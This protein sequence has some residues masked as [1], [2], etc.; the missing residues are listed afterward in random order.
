MSNSEETTSEFV[1]TMY[2]LTFQRQV[3]KLLATN[4]KFAVNYG[5][6]IKGEYF[7]SVSLR[8]ISS[9]VKDFVNAYEK[10]V[11]LGTIVVKLDDYVSS[12]G[13]STDASKDILKEAKAIFN[14]NVNS[15]Q[16]I[17][18][19]LVSFARRQELKTA[20]YQSVEI[21]EKSEDYEKVLQLVDKAVG[22]GTGADEG[23]TFEDLYTLRENYA[24][25]YDT[26]KLIPTGFKKVDRCMEGGMAA[27]ELHVVQA[28]P[29]TGKSFFGVCV[30]AN[31]LRAGKSVFHVSFE[32]SKEEIAM[33]Y[34]QNL[35]KMEK[36]GVQS[37]DK[38]QYNHK[39]KLYEKYK[40]NLYMQYWTQKTAN[41]LDVRAWIS[42]IRAKKGVKPDLI[43]VDY[44]DLMLPTV[45]TKN[46]SMYEDAGQVYT[47]LITLGDYFQCPILTFAQPQREAWDLLSE[48]KVIESHHLAHSAMKA[49]KCHSIS[50]LNFSPKSDMGA[51]Y[52]DI[53]RRGTSG[54]NIKM[55][56]DLG[57][58][59]FHE[60][61]GVTT[62]ED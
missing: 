13:L 62:D 7:D 27:G 11:D 60:M 42:R 25:K 29:K 2:T 14:A 44:D 23:L 1:D 54:V 33:R 58:S 56:K 17:I 35:L 38:D 8:A 47:D 26:T 21:L 4:Y 32:L 53:V 20:L 39:I 22:V 52:V 5:N 24:K 40:P 28:K 9:I 34:T 37:M 46:D 41:A 18:D 48:N 45:R 49:H 19:K 6:I 43:I 51:F 16:F 30:G 55:K 36:I 61:D 3:L 59:V 57:R 10:E 50:S 12:K 15:E 31:N